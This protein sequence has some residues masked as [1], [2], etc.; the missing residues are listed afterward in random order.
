M[1]V[2]RDGFELK[3]IFILNL[4]VGLQLRQDGGPDTEL[5]VVTL[6][7]LAYE[8]SLFLW[9]SSQRWPN[10]LAH[11]VPLPLPRFPHLVCSFFSSAI[12]RPQ[13]SA[14]PPSIILFVSAHS[15][16][17]FKASRGYKKI[18]WPLYQLK[19]NHWILHLT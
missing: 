15:S 7:V 8:R 6:A 13:S 3:A 9:L 2:L 14:V 18:F 16:V 1:V 19:V 5:R 11:P 4:K 12:L 10:L 17:I